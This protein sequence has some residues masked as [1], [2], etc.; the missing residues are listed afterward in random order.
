MCRSY[1]SKAM[2]LHCY[3]KLNSL[4]HK[5]CNLLAI[6]IVLTYLNTRN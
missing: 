2:L 3:R 5:V 4:C 1:E 6:F